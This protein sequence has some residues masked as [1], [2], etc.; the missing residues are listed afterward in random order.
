MGPGVARSLP[1]SD[2]SLFW[3]QHDS[4][5]RTKASDSEEKIS[6]L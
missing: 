1:R 5:L 3:S 6:D 4:Q 2:L